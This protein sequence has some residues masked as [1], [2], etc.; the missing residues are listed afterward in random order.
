MSGVKQ[1]GGT[2]W[3]VLSTGVPCSQALRASK[4]LFGPWASAQL[5]QSLSL[6]GY[7]CF[8]MTDLSY[9][10]KGKSSGGG[11]CHVGSTRA[12]S[13]FDA[14]TFAFRMTGAYT[15]AQIKQFFHLA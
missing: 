6:P 10:G 12:S 7:S 2:T 3:T 13:V 5:G 1:K 8:K 14:G 11:L 15:I 9:D 4:S